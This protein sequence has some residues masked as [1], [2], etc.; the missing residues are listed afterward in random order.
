MS[1]NVP[2]FGDFTKKI[3]ET[4]ISHAVVDDNEFRIERISD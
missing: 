1:T 4:T 2:K 3:D